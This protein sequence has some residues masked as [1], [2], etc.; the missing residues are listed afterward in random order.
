MITVRTEEIT[1]Q[2][3]HEYLARNKDNRKVV[4]SHLEDLASRQVRGDWKVN[5]DP[6]RFD[7]DGFL[8]DGQHR[9]NMVVKTGIPITTVVV[10][11][12]E[13][14]AFLT[15]DV[16]RKRTL[17]TVLDIKGASNPN[18]LAPA[19]QKV[20]SYLTARPSTNVSHEQHLETL[21]QHPEIQT[22]VNFYMERKEQARQID[23]T[24]VVISAHYLF[25]RVDKDRGDDF[26]DKVITGVGIQDQDDPI[27]KLR[28]LLLDWR[29]KRKREK[30]R[31]VHVLEVFIRAWAY[32]TDGRPV[33][34]RFKPAQKPGLRPAIKNFPQEL[35]ISDTAQDADDDDED[36]LDGA[37]DRELA[38]VR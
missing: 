16:G 38:G 24:S 9:L 33:K 1:V 23:F 35:I 21:E 12:I 18:I 30:I 31:E 5:G 13:P 27:Y 29:D 20:R 25:T 17:A 10:E 4:P 2:R 8:R 7:S 26:I 11:G 14:D 36:S 19:L 28:S 37:E 3:A 15:L 22:S 32:W 34:M 6:I